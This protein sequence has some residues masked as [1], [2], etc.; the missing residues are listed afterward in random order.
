MITIYD[1]HYKISILNILKKENRK[2]KKNFY[3][4]FEYVVRG[5]KYVVKGTKYVVQS[6]N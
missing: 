2:R 3:N 1:Y 6:L 4:V 5:M